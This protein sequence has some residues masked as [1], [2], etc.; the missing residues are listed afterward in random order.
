MNLIKACLKRRKVTIGET[1][2][3]LMAYYPRLQLTWL[4]LVLAEIRGAP[5]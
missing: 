1:E 5:C 2:I 3:N 4:D